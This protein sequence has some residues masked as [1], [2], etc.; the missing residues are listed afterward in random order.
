MR[1]GCVFRLC[2]RWSVFCLIMPKAFLSLVVVSIKF[3]A[4]MVCPSFWS[5]QLW[6]CAF[7]IFTI[8]L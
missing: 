8:V 5:R 7:I 2:I 1:V 6:F 3:D 4:G